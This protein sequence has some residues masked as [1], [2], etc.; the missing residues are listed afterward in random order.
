MHIDSTWNA[1]RM[2]TFGVQAQHSQQQFGAQAQVQKQVKNKV[3]VTH[4]ISKQDPSH[5][6][7]A[8]GSPCLCTSTAEV[9]TKLRSSLSANFQADVTMQAEHTVN[10][11]C[12]SESFGQHLT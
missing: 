9:L 11:L 3:A 4:Y 7:T 8:A 6:A 12:V 2:M 1:L 5:T 10:V